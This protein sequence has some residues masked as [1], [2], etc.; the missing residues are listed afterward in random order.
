MQQTGQLSHDVVPDGRDDACVPSLFVGTT[1]P[2]GVAGTHL[3]QLAFFGEAGL[4]E[5]SNV[6]FVRRQFP[7]HQRRP[8]FRP[9]AGQPYT[10][11]QETS[12]KELTQRLANLQVAAAVADEN[13]S[14]ENRWCQLRDT[15]QSTVL[16]VH[17]HARRQHMDRF[18]DNDAAIGNAFAEQNRLNKAYITHPTDN[19]EAAFY[20]GRCPVQKWLRET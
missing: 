8:S 11:S 7:S 19:N 18:Y 16:A 15:V 12:S 5:R 14:V 20:R 3:L 4:A 17:G 2:E 9:T 10:T 1:T 6:D 13:A